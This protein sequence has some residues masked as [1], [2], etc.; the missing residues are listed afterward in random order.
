M[1]FVMMKRITAARARC[2]WWLI[3]VMSPHHTHAARLSLAAVASASHEC[4][5]ST[6][7][8]SMR[9]ATHHIEH[10]RHKGLLHYKT[11]T[12]T[13]IQQTNTAFS[14]LTSNKQRVSLPYQW[15]SMKR[16][17]DVL[18]RKVSST[19]GSSTLKRWIVFSHCTTYT[20]GTLWSCR[21]FSK[22]PIA[23]P[24]IGNTRTDGATR[25]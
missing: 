23:I 10:Q 15:W 4:H 8:R 6:T 14:L 22:K 9:K 13:V 1:L 25:G 24:A 11:A 12:L 7:L 19:H 18:L 17:D 2:E 21:I 20:R 3:A 5:P 16:K